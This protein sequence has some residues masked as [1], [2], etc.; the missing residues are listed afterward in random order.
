MVIKFWSL[1]DLERYFGRSKASV[2]TMRKDP[3]FP[4]AKEIQG[5][6]MFDAHAIVAWDKERIKKARAEGIAEIK[7]NIRNGGF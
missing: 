7:A 1:R 6:Q 4:L 2:W 3:T 5:R